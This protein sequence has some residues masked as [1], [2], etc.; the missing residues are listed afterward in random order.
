MNKWEI[1]AVVLA[2]AIVPCLAVAV[3]A[4]AEHA[5]AAV[6]VAGA[7]LTSVL[8]VLSEGFHRQPFVDLAVVSAL[9]SIVGGLA[10]ARLMER[11]L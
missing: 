3:L 10:F 8:M 9:I 5:L 1:V 7:L 4:G 2:A 11:G 6:E